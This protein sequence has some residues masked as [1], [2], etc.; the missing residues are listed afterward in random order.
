MF[1]SK[2]IGSMNMSCFVDS[3]FDVAFEQA[4]VTPSGPAR[5]E[6]FRT[7][8]MR[9]D[10]MAPMRPR[11]VGDNLMLKRGNVIGPFATS[12]DWLQVIT[13]GVETSATSTSK[14]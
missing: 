7:M 12:N 13:L 11:P 1:Y 6:Q 3:A 14:R 10:A 9:L 4:L 8:Q 2:S 5:I